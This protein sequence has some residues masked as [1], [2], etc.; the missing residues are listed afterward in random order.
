VHAGIATQHARV[1]TWRELRT[2]LLPRV[3]ELGYTALL[4]LGLQEHGFYPSFGY[5]VTSYFA[6][7]ERFG[8]PSELQA[9]STTLRA[10]SRLLEAQLDGSALDGSRATHPSLTR[11]VSSLA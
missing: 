11:R 10:T 6:P 2:E 5:Q 4:L 9:S 1:G 3:Y 7:S 8:T